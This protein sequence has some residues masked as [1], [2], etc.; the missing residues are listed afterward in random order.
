M[1]TNKQLITSKMSCDNLINN[2]I[3]ISNSNNL[4]VDHFISK[5]ILNNL[6]QFSNITLVDLSKKAFT[7]TASIIRFCKKIGFK[8]YVDFKFTLLQEYR[9]NKN[10]D[11]ISLNG[12]FC[13]ENLNSFLE[14]FKKVNLEKNIYFFN[15]EIISLKNDKKLFNILNENNLNINFDWLSE[16]KYKHIDLKSSL[17]IFFSNNLPKWFNNSQSKYF[18]INSNLLQS[19]QIFDYNIKKLIFP[20]FFLTHNYSF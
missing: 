14:N 10:K 19:N 20:L 1:E 2:L 12:C 13:R 7:S 17:F 5:T 9:I 8:G 11:K 18:Q 6:E 15:S 4:V 3:E 16:E